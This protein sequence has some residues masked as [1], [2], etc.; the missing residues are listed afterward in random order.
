MAELLSPELFLVKNGFC[1]KNRRESWNERKA[2][3]KPRDRS[4]C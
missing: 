1:S 2:A 3:E 4:R